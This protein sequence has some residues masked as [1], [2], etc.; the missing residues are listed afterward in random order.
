[1]PEYGTTDHYLGAQGAAYFAWQSAGGAFGA[2]I[3]RRKFAAYIRATDVVLDFG[4]GGGFLLASLACAERI[5][6]E[7]NP[8][9]RAHA[10]SLGLRCY[11]DMTPVPDASVDVI[12]SDHALEHVPY[13]LAA[14]REWHRLLK[15]GGRAIVV[16]PIDDWHRPYRP[17]D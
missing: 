2:Q 13:P 8:L 9:A 6:V 15:P 16:T 7:I 11:A 4:C 3:N 12:V 10:A 1:M 17:D 14:L 5:G